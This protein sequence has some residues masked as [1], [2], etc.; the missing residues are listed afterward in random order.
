[1]AALYAVA[2]TEP[3][4]VVWL[5]WQQYL[6]WL[7]G[8]L[9][10][11]DNAWGERVKLPGP[12][13]PGQHFA[14]IGPTGEGKT[15]HAGG[16]LGQRKWVIALDPKGEDETLSAFGFERVRSMWEPGWQYRARHR[17]DA[18]TWKDVW[19]RI[20]AGQPARLV[21]GG[22]AYSDSEVAR[23]KQLMIDATKFVTYVPGFTFYID[24]LEIA[25]SQELFNIRALVNRMLVS[26][27]NKG[28]KPT[29]VLT[30]YQA[31]AWVTKHA[32]RQA[33][34]GTIWPTGDRDMIKA[35]A[36]ALGRD[37]RDVAACVDQLPAFHTATIPR[38]KRGGP[39][40]LT[41]AP[42]VS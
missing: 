24:E 1:M 41:S 3:G 14:L 39:M 27:R 29:S 19:K 26:A 17:E 15:T 16:M 37:W 30:A 42:K 22:S 35:V 10:Y 34:K 31:Q 38:G 13:E 4:Q 11:A 40:V 36:Q 2:N 20:D 6:D 9:R 5:E 33:K 25:T 7:C 32:I 28:G 18:K 8:K 21:V 12:W 23:L